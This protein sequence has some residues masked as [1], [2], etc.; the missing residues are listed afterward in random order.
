MHIDDLQV[1]QWVA[2]EHDLA[3]NDQPNDF[4]GNCQRE[5]RVDGMPLK[6]LSISLPFVAV[7]D[8]QSRFVLDSRELVL[9]R[10]DKR[11]VKSLTS[12]PRLATD[13]GS[14][15]I[16]N[17]P[18]QAQEQPPERACPVCHER[19]IERFAGGVWL[20]ACRQCGFT[21]GRGSRSES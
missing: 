2:I 5:S 13:H 18:R 8:G 21:G 7:T 20:L 17:Q 15:V 12:T 4:W 11:F 9:C 14:F 19:L 16:T 3:A 10:L 6:I 1:G